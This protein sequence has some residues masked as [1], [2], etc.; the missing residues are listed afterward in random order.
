MGC[1]HLPGTANACK[2][3]DFTILAH[4][5][6]TSETWVET[7]LTASPA[8][9][10]PCSTHELA[11][12]VLR[13]IKPKLLINNEFVDSLTGKTFNTLDP[14]TGEVLVEVAEAQAEDVDRAVKAAK[15]VGG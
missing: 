13:R 7:R 5:S 3:L 2:V 1:S 14:R 6:T 11:Q 4:L 12:Q 8:L 10:P 15:K 9:L